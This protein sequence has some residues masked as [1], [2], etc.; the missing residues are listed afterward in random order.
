MKVSNPAAMYQLL[1]LFRDPSSSAYACLLLVAA[2][3]LLG[4]ATPLLRLVLG[5]SIRFFW[6]RPGRFA[7]YLELC[8][9]SPPAS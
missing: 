1:A 9:P 2:G 3:W 8:P 5:R 6:C 7:V 4:K